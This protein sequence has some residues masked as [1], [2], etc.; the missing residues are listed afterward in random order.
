M[1]GLK[2]PRPLFN[3][4]GRIRS[5][6]GGC[7]CPGDLANPDTGLDSGTGFNTLTKHVLPVIDTSPKGA[8]DRKP[9]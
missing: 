5:V 7:F 6:P 1:P 3:I 8:L 4:A 2:L 9:N